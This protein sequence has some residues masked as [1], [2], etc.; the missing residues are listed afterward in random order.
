MFA[1]NEKISKR[2][3]T[4]LMVMDW[5]GK[6]SLLFPV[7][8][9]TGAGGG[10]GAEN[11][12]ALLLAVGTAFVYTKILGSVARLV[13]TDLQT[14]L[15]ERLGTVMAQVTAWSFLICLLLNQAYLA[16]AV[17]RVSTMF[18]LPEGS[19]Y[20]CGAFF[21]IAGWI[22][23]AGSLQK[24]ARVAECLYPLVLILLCLMLGASAWSVQWKYVQQLIPKQMDWT[25]VLKKAIWI[26]NCLS[27]MSVS[28]YQVP[29]LKDPGCYS[30]ALKRSV[31]IVGG[32]QI[33]LFVIMIGA[34]GEQD[35][36]Q[37]HW[38]ALVLMSNVNM[39]GGF[40]Q[41]WDIVFLSV[42]LLSLFAA[43]GTGIYY[44]GMIL[45]ELFPGKTKKTWQKWSVIVS[46]VVAFLAGS[47]ERMERIFLK[48]AVEGVLMILIAI[49]LILAVIER[50]AACKK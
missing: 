5:L 49:L 46:A 37:M 17:G 1:N 4:R 23:A 34:F 15:R 18:L 43:A 32:F 45:S 48:G 28:L 31:L 12:V 42:L 13:R 8:M 24:R 16:R 2:Q 38:P 41:R 14:Y 6:F 35:F 39:P 26:F 25:E 33:L 20:V 36:R 3:V 44:M 50:E 47:Y 30:K 21:L 10:T 22:T 29:H 9:T 7:V 27:G 11:A 19:E 40:L